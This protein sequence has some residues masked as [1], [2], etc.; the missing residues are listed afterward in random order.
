MIDAMKETPV[1][2]V[3]LLASPIL[4]GQFRMLIRDRLDLHRLPAIG[5]GPKG[6]RRV[7]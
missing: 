4:Y 7:A 5:S 3:N 2:A 6:L 1:E